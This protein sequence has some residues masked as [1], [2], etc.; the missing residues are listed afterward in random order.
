MDTPIKIPNLK[1]VLV[2][3]LKESLLLS[4]MKDN[5]M[6][7]KKAGMSNKDRAILFLNSKGYKVIGFQESKES[8]DFFLIVDPEGQEELIFN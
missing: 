6:L 5:H 3:E 4:A 2:E 7:P 8:G 1:I